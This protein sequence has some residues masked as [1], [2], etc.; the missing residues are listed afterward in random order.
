MVISQDAIYSNCPSQ[1]RELAY[2]KFSY[3]Y[4]YLRHLLAL[5]AKI[6]PRGAPDSPLD[7]DFMMLAAACNFIRDDT[8]FADMQRYLDMLVEAY[9]PYV[10][11]DRD[12]YEQHIIT[13]ATA[14]RS[15][16]RSL[17]C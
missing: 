13:H 2:S 3:T 11:S 16:S 4:D 17:V 14:S 7:D 1:I 12:Q 6:R 5:R 8:S 9:V 10:P 15:R